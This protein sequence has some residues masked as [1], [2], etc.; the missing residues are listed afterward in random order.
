MTS[1]MPIQTDPGEDILWLVHAVFPSDIVI[2]M[3]LSHSASTLPMCEDSTASKLIIW[4]YR[5]TS[6]SPGLPIHKAGTFL[7]QPVLY[8]WCNKE[9]GM[10]YPVCGMMHI[11]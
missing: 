6:V 3:K 9:H 4:L 2:S 7:L 1:F 5:V 11:K 10:C 8:N